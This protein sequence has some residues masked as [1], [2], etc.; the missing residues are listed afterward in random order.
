MTR[1]KDGILNSDWTNLGGGDGFSCVFDPDDPDVVYFESQGGA[2]QRISLSTGESR[3]QRPAAGEGQPEF[4]FHW[5][6]PLFGSRHEKGALYLAGNRVFKLSAKGEEWKTV[7]PDLSAQDPGRTTASG[8]GAETYGVVYTLAESPVKAGLLWA[9]TDDGKVWI[10]QNGGESWTDLTLRLPAAVKG[11]WI[12]RIEASAHDAAAAYLAVDAH[13]TGVDSPLVYRTPDGGRSWESVAGNLPAHGPVKVLREDPSNA[14]LLF[15][16]TELGLFVSLDRG[17]HWTK[18]PEL[19][20]VAVDDLVIHPRERDL[21]I[22]THGRSLYVVDDIRPLEELT[23]EAAAAP[24]H[25]FPPR[26]APGFHPL[27]GTSDWGGTAVFKGANPPAGAILTFHVAEYTGEPVKIEIETAGGQPVARLSAPGI[28]GFGRIAWDLKP[29]KELL[30]E[31][32]GEGPKF[33]PSGEYTVTLKHGK[34]KMKQKL[35]VQIAPGIETR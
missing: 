26:P 23:S 2:L 22:A 32:G 11:Q 25:L 16:G 17:G 3:S 7:S 33:V 35:Q 14:N 13:R 31:Y 18:W 34:T 8:S 9:G 1:S 19:P 5:N 15:V 12:T 27:P 20:T 24:A 28:A 10:T 30:T 6:A 4:R 29:S 21:V